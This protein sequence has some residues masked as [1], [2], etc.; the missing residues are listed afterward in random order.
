M[1]WERPQPSLALL[2]WSSKP[3]LM[4]D[5]TSDLCTIHACLIHSALLTTKMPMTRGRMC[6][7]LTQFKAAQVRVVMYFLWLNSV[8]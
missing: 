2:A 5:I 1:P 7:D 4:L 3:S 6:L 8:N